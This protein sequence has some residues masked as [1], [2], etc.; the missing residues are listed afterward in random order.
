KVADVLADVGAPAMNPSIQ[1]A[2]LGFKPNVT[3]PDV[4]DSYTEHVL[5]VAAHLVKIEAR[6]G[7]LVTLGLEPEPR[8]FLETTDE[9]VDYFTKHVY[10]GKSAARLA[11]LAD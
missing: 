4:V 7:H 9:T 6:T 8:C 11:T 2:P 10:T 1:S 5:R 3:G